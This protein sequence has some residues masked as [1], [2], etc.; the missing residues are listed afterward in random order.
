M[1]ASFP[2][3][4]EA[5]AGFEATAGAGRRN[6][7]LEGGDRA[8]PFSSLQARL[9]RKRVTAEMREAIPVVFMAFDLLYADG[10]MTM[11][12]PLQQRRQVLEELVEREQPRTRV[13]SRSDQRAGSRRS[14]SLNC[15]AGGQLRRG[16]CLRPP[17]NWKAWPN[18]SRPTWMPRARGK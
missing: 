18:W 2:E 16:W 15:G 10:E 3:I 1:T 11:E 14:C 7:G 12:K 13:G 9:G 6:P 5:F 8:L 4:V 17:S